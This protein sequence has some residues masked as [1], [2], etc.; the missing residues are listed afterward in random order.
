MHNEN[1]ATQADTAHRTLDAHSTHSKELKHVHVR[2]RRARWPAPSGRG[3][4]ATWL[5]LVRVRGCT[6]VRVRGRE[7]G[8]GLGIRVRV[9]GPHVWGVAEVR[10]V[11]ARVVV[12]PV[13][14]LR[15]V[16]KVPPAQGWG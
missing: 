7:I 1:D 5:G 4:I 13:G 6:V 14:P 15:A 16:A 10:T 8:L 3:A 2:G 9:R 11:A 12:P